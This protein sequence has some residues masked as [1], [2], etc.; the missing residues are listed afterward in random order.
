MR[1]ISKLE[2]SLKKYYRNFVGTFIF[3]GRFRRRNPISRIF[4][5]DRGP[6]SV[7][8]YYID[9]FLHNHKDDVRG[10]VLE[11]GDNKY[12]VQLGGHRVIKSDVL[13]ATAG[14]P[15]T[16]IVADLTHADEIPSNTFDCIILTQTLQMI[17]NSRAAMQHISRILKPEG[18]LL[19]TVPGIC[20]IS[21]FDMD[22]WGDY[23]RF[24]TLSAQRLFEE[25]FP[26]DH[27]KVEAHGNVLVAT[28]LLH[29]LA[30]CE[31][32]SKELDYHDPEYQ[33]IITIRAVKPA[34]QL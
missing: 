2:R 12:T 25:C 6:Q 15:N 11:I 30:S 16:T 8:R 3:F 26:P 1:I 7:A 13:H 31:L 24:T 33:V 22:R 20:Q 27:I 14:N 19:A 5:Y 28:A 32:R 21:R 4:G 23:W 29:G 10:R 9:K 34:H 17:Y 18:V